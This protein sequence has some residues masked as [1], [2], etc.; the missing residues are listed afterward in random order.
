MDRLD[1]ALRE[2]TM[3]PRFFRNGGGVPRLAREEPRDADGALVGFFNQRSGKTGITYKEALDE[4]LCFGWI[5]GVRKSVDEGRY[6]GASLRAR[7][8]ASGASSTSSAWGS[9]RRS[10]G[11]PRPAAR[12]STGATRSGPGVD[13]RRASVR[14][15]APTSSGVPRERARLGL[16]PVAAARVPPSRTWYVVSAKKDETRLRRL[17]TLI[18]LCAKGRP[19]PGLDRRRSPRSEK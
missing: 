10:A 11:W 14:S 8:A 12:R 18:E 1:D 17:D 4:S 5:D 3:A 16:L 13:L 19:L 6:T 15:L 2:R 9:S 7:R